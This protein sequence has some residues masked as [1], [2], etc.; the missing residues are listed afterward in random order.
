LETGDFFLIAEMGAHGHIVWMKKFFALL[1]ALLSAWV[2]FTP[3]DLPPIPFFFIDEAIALLL[4]TKSM[5]YLGFD[6]ARIL[7]FLSNRVR[8]NASTTPP[9]AGTGRGKGSVIDI[10]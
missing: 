8:K 2:L 5:S 3:F 10:E 6:I 4:F 1:I 7:P 9:A